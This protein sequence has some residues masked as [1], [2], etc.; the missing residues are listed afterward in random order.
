MITNDKPFM[1]EKEQIATKISGDSLIMDMAGTT[2]SEVIKDNQV[3]K[4]NKEIEIYADAY[5]KH[6]NELE[7]SVSK[8][9]LDPEKLEILPIGNYV[10]VKE[11]TTNPF[12]RIV[13]DS[14]TG[15]ITDMGG[16]APVFKNTDSGETD[17]E[18]AFIITGAIQ[19]IGPECKW[20]QPGD[21][22][23]FTKPSAVPLP[24]YKAGLTLVNETRIL[25][26]VNEGLSERFEKVKI[27]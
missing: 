16:M 23:F 1:T 18:D 26:I 12:Q 11:F 20:C 13:R 9:A 7:E 15:I 17:I 5:N 2:A 27:K 22:I 19:E 6:V 8:L 24:F 21:A 14:K 3:K 4:F 10:I 25:A